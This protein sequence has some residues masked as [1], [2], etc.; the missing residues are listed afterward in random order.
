MKAE[1]NS[2]KK[3]EGEVQMASAAYWGNRAPPRHRPS[4]PQPA[5]QLPYTVNIML[6]STK[7]SSTSTFISSSTDT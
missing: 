6:I 5:T 3:I 7:F 4:Y 2:G 1:F